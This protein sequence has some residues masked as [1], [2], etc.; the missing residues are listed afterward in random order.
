MTT[1]RGPPEVLSPDLVAFFTVLREGLSTQTS[2]SAL[3]T[4]MSACVEKFSTS[5]EM[6]TW[7]EMF[8]ACASTAMMVASSAPG[9][10][11]VV[12]S[13]SSFDHIFQRHQYHA[14]GCSCQECR[15]QEASRAQE[16]ECTLAWPPLMQEAL[17]PRAK[18]E[19]CPCV[20]EAARWI[21][22]TWM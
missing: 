6:T 19:E 5:P 8:R 4:G 17:T 10:P 3:S 16:E 20:L 2:E 14:L 11:P 18:E 9:V 22:V 15:R 13:A 21:T 1:S 7:L 12:A